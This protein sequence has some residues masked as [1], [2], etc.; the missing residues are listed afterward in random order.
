MS[1]KHYNESAYS[2]FNHYQ[3]FK[4]NYPRTIVRVKLLIVFPSV[5]NHYRIMFPFIYRLSIIFIESC[6]VMLNQHITITIIIPK[7]LNKKI[8]FSNVPQPL[9]KTNSFCFIF[10]TMFLLKG[11]HAKFTQPSLYLK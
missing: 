9:L 2:T 1:H 8:F 6:F 5:I 11:Y 7:Y 3:N 4:I 10:I